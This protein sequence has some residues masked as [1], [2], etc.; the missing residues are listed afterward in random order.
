MHLMGG[1]DQSHITCPGGLT[2]SAL[3]VIV[4]HYLFAELG[5]ASLMS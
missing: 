2:V 3:S 5:S 1:L 4:K